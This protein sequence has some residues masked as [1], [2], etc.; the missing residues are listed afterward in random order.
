MC[1]KV[2][3]HHRICPSNSLT[4]SLPQTLQSANVTLFEFPAQKMCLGLGPTGQKIRHRDSVAGPNDQ[5]QSLLQ[6]W[7]K[8]DGFWYFRVRHRECVSES[9]AKIRWWKRTLSYSFSAAARNADDSFPKYTVESREA[10]FNCV[11]SHTPLN[12]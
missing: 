12:L 1:L 5:R 2:R 10:K 3:F 7:Q 11:I 4:H 8:C 6:I 9:V